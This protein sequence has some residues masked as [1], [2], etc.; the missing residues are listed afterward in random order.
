[1]GDAIAAANSQ[2]MQYQQMQILQNLTQIINN[3][4]NACAK[5]TDCYKNQQIT[6]AKNRYDAAVLTEKNAPKLVEE[7]RRDYLIAAK[8]QSGANEALKQHY[9]QMGQQ[10][11][12]KLSQQFDQW[13]ADMSNK[14]SSAT[15]DA[16]SIQTL[17]ETNTRLENILDSLNQQN[18][19]ATNALNLL[20]RK[21]HYASQDISLI[22]NVEYYFK[23]LYW[24]A[25]LTWIACII[26]ERRFTMKTGTLFVIF[27][28][29]FFLQD[30]IM[31][32]ISVI[33]PADVR[34]KW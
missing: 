28:L 30:K 4:N 10:E 31:D 9:L 16:E 6:D 3:A 18:D 32:R 2:N 19:D 29:F 13:F 25:F 5:G 14:V 34:L 21:I 15:T 24:L 11:K 7:S 33:I 12:A 27:T 8:G 22:N 23:L 26:Y 1:M 17:N 20:E